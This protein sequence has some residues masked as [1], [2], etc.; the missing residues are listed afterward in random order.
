MLPSPQTE[1]VGGKV[2]DLIA[3]QSDIG[4]V[5]VWRL[6]KRAQRHGG[7]RGAVG[8]GAEARSRVGGSFLLH[9]FDRMAVAAPLLCEL[10][11]KGGIADCLR[12]NGAGRAKGGCRYQQRTEQ[13]AHHHQLFC[14]NNSN[15]GPY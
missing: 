7:C 15:R 13:D 5:P 2:V 11:A 14:Y 3:A 8:N 9:G 6:Q 4:H 12:A 10:V 1:D